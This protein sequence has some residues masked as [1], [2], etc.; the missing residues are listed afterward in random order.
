MIQFLP[1]KG[2]G[3]VERLWKRAHLIGMALFESC[4]A[5][6]NEESERQTE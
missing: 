2:N 6:N 3:S 5:V 1:G 4:M